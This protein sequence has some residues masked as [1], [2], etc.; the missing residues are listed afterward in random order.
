MK[1]FFLVLAASAAVA[2]EWEATQRIPLDQKIEITTL[3]GTRTRAAFVSATGQ[4]MVVR[5]NSGER[6][7]ARAEIR[8]VRVADP[9][10]RLR[11]GLIWTAVGAGAGVAIGTAICLPCL[12][13][14]TS[15]KFIGPGIAIGAGLGA[16]GFLTVPYRTVYKSK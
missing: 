7:I 12:G 4:A 14:G 9:A 11:N 8:T 10:R 6:S 16:L 3:S 2:G 15:H 5:E 13:E 1:L